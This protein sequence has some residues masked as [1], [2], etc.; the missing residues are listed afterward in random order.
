MTLMFCV[1]RNYYEYTPATLESLFETNP[2]V[3]RV[4]LFIE[5]DVFPY[6]LDPRVEVVNL[7][8]MNQYLLPTS[9]N[10]KTPYS[11]MT[12]VRCYVSKYL[13]ED[14]II[15]VDIDTLFTGDISELWN[16]DLEDNYLC[17]VPEKQDRSRF[18]T[19]LTSEYSDPYFNAGVIMLNLKKIRE[20]G[21]DDFIMEII[22][23][24]QLP[25]PDQDALNIV[26]KG[27]VKYVSN[28]FNNCRYTGGEPGV[29]NII[30]TT[31]F[32]AWDP[33]C[34]HNKLW[35]KYDSYKKEI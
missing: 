27:K 7:H 34:V 3:E 21:T 23:S 20:E 18:L 12:F 13:I 8:K 31:P 16:T 1:T 25:Y 4:Y 11:I 2:K 17:A 22:N 14:K 26:C 19:H 9:P 33:N 24:R 35:R 5:D 30:H 15:Y 6:E 28:K 32:K 29:W 10:Y